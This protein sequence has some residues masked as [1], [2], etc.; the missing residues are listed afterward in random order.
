MFGDDGSLGLAARF[1]PF[2]GEAV[3]ECSVAV[4]EHRIRGI[5]EERVAELVL[6]FDSIAPSRPTLHDFAARETT[7]KLGDFDGLHRLTEQRRDAAGREGLPEHARRTE[8]A[9]RIGI[10][11]IETRLDG[12]EHRRWK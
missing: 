1:E 2:A 11:R 12:T 7:K 9:A 4:G 8:D 3:R 5:A 6:G 10:E